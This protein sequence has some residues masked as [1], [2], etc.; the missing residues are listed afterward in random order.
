MVGRKGCTLGHVTILAIG[1]YNLVRLIIYNPAEGF[2]I[3]FVS[4]TKIFGIE[5]IKIGTNTVAELKRNLSWLGN[6]G[7]QRQQ[8]LNTI[9]SNNLL[10]F[11]VHVVSCPAT[12]HPRGFV[13]SLVCFF[14]FFCFHFFILFVKLT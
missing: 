11:V 9:N 12:I 7:K 6:C 14:S 2:Y 10:L 4:R 5:R 13:F 3:V 8:V 1:H